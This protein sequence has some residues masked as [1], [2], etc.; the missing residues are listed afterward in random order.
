MVLC[1]K[2]PQA[3]IIAKLNLFRPKRSLEPLDI[4]FKNSNNKM[5]YH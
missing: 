3:K 4:I 1:K 2:A 5:Q